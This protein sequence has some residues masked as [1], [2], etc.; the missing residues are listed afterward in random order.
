MSYSN[1]QNLNPRPFFT[2]FRFA[3]QNPDKTFFFQSCDGLG[4]TLSGQEY[5]KAT[6][7][8]H[9][10][11]WFME[12]LTRESIWFAWFGLGFS[13]LTPQTLRIS[14]VPKNQKI[15]SSQKT[16]TADLE[17]GLVYGL[18]V[19][20]HRHDKHMLWDCLRESSDGENPEMVSARTS[21]MCR[22]STFWPG[23]RPPILAPKLTQNI[24]QTYPKLIQ[25]L[26]HT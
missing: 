15:Q 22:G 10:V 4:D 11:T 23:I 1:P 8:R 9:W 2:F 20:W 5:F 12:N 14:E 19:A 16:S 21:S 7:L 17:E 13:K 6:N 18:E 24:P 25:N 3:I 26:S